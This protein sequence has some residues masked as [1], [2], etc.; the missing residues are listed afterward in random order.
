MPSSA[1]Q[2]LLLG[3]E[4]HPCSPTFLSILDKFGRHLSFTTSMLP[5]LVCMKW[6]LAWGHPCGPGVLVVWSLSFVILKHVCTQFVG[7]AWPSIFPKLMVPT[8]ML[9]APM[10]L[11]IPTVS[12]EL[13][14]APWP[15][16]AGR[17]FLGRIWSAK[18]TTAGD[19]GPGEVAASHSDCGP[20]QEA[21]INQ[22]AENS[23]DTAV[24]LMQARLL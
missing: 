12:G 14:T 19:L 10:M 5:H 15:P 22:D 1:N 2:K 21:S 24:S 18:K 20:F 4:I 9:L 23:L 16:I 11:G 17:C 13:V 3:P 8:W 6:R 7:R